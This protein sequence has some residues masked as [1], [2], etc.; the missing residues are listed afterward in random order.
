MQYSTANYG[1]GDEALVQAAATSPIT[2]DQAKAAK[3][4][5]KRMRAALQAWLKYRAI[6]DAAAAGRAPPA[7]LKR[8]GA[9]TPP[10]PVIALRLQ[11]ER[12]AQE[13]ALATDLHALLAEVFD[14]ASLP[15]PNLATNR[16]A[17]V[18]LAQIAIAGRLP[19]EA[20]GPTPQ[21][22]I[23]LWPLVIVVGAIAYVISSKIRNDAE[24]A[25]ERERYQCI[26]DGYCTD[27]DFW[28]KVAAVGVVGW[29]VWYRMGLGERVT[30]A[31]RRRG[32]RR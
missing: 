13:A 2:A 3:A 20:A 6:N 10:A 24:I 1:M 4:E 19:G 7:V 12:A 31:L 27:S 9:K 28:V 14:P 18:E 23:W 5:L 21:G 22:L 11:R 29:L 32:P 8:P 16:N 26:R 25:K 30:G 17:A 15:S